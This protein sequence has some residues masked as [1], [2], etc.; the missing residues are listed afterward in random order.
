MASS[1]LFKFPFVRQ[2]VFG[3]PSLNL[4]FIVLSKPRSY[5]SAFCL[6]VSPACWKRQG[7]RM[8]EGKR[9]LNSSRPTCPHVPGTEGLSSLFSPRWLA[10]EG[11]ME[12]SSLRELWLGEVTTLSSVI[13][14]AKRIEAN[15]EFRSGPHASTTS[16]RPQTFFF[17]FC[18]SF[19]SLG[20][21]I[22]LVFIILLPTTLDSFPFHLFLIVNKGRGL[23]FHLA[24]DTPSHLGLFSVI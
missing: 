21:P 13:K 20:N 10:G 3:V 24:S 11:G 23:P 19:V 15:P 2:I 22:P 7:K 4:Y 1:I 9:V 12:S 17:F 18:F 5:L 14:L 6:F 16:Q 8:R